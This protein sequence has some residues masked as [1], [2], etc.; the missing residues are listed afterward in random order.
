MN[1][2]LEIAPSEIQT[3]RRIDCEIKEGYPRFPVLTIDTDS[4]IVL[5]NV[6]MGLNHRLGKGI[7]NFQIGKYS[8]IADDVVFLIDL[9]HDYRAVF[10]GH[11]TA[12][13]EKR[14]NYKEQTRRK[15]QIII[16][17]DCWIG[18][19]ATI[20]NGVTIHNGAIVAARSVVTKDVPPYAI[21]GGN[22]AKIIKYRFD[23]KQIDALLKIAWWDWSTEQIKQAESSMYKSVDGF[24]ADHIAEAEQKLGNLA[25]CKIDRLMNQSG[26][27]FLFF[28]DMNEPYAI[29]KKVIKQFVQTYHHYDAELLLYLNVDE[30]NAEKNMDTLLRELKQYEEYDSYI[31][32]YSN[33]I[34][35]SSLLREVDYYITNRSLKN[36]S[37]MCKAQL[38][39]VTCLSGVDSEIFKA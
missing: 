25:K 21:V 36:V 39:G 34:E 35:E 17:N 2:K 20:M 14:K 11:I 18:H 29:Y 6:T 33:A 16:E 10:Q 22:P 8:A 13:V 24:I 9:N 28:V 4:Y 38:F 27:L 15:G 23:E 3:I 30:E 19:N 7:H 37:R 5:A 26:K 12:L 32:I 1:I 31:Q